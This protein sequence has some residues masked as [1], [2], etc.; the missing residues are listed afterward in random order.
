MA[1][2]A[3]R[4]YQVEYVGQISVGGRTMHRLHWVT[5]PKKGQI[6]VSM[7]GLRSRVPE[8]S[9]RKEHAWEW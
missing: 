7:G 4:W 9:K 6:Q 8:K 2:I 1:R 3:Q 5:G